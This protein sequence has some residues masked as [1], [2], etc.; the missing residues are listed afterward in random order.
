LEL[1]HL[2]A[3]ADKAVRK[4]EERIG[5]AFSRSRGGCRGEKGGFLEGDPTI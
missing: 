1:D 2:E 4:L 5:G 3:V